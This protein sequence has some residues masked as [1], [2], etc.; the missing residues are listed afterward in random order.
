MSCED[1]ITQIDIIVAYDET[2]DGNCEYL[3]ILTSSDFEM[4][5]PNNQND[6]LWLIQDRHSCQLQR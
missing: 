4:H 5:L 3:F 6:H 1:C 2:V